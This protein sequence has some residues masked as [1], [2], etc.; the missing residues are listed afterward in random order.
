MLALQHDTR[1]PTMLVEKIVD[2]QMAD[3][4]AV[5]RGSDLNPDQR[6]QEW[7]EESRRRLRDELGTRGYDTE[8]LAQRA[9]NYIARYP[10]L[11]AALEPND[12]KSHP[13]LFMAIVDHVR[14]HGI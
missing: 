4:V 3:A 2:L 14:R 11:R 6:A 8:R 13:D 9:A 12:L 5:A 1:L 7:R 10:R